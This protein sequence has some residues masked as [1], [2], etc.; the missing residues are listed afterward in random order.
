MTTDRTAYIE[1]LRALADTLEQNPD[2]P[3]PS[4]GSTMAISWYSWD[5]AA[6]MAAIA[7]ALPCDWVKDVTGADEDYAH[8][9]LRGSVAGLN[10]KITS[11]R[12]TVCTRRVT[13]TREVTEE[14]PDPDAP[15]VTVT[16]TVEDVEWDCHPVLAAAPVTAPQP[17]VT[18]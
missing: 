12:N 18:A 16:T 3:L 1:G 4:H 9:H 10:L 14:V 6:Q 15:M 11:Y 7:R 5:D 17:A 2:L 8:F 13:G